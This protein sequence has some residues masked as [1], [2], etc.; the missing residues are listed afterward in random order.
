[1]TAPGSRPASRPAGALLALCAAV[2]ASASQA[3]V[4]VVPPRDGAA[5]RALAAAAAMDTVL[6]APGVH[7]GPLRI[8]GR[9]VVLRG[10]GATIAGRRT[11][12]VL[13]V[14][15]SGTVVEDLEV[16][17]G[18]S[19][20]I[21]TDAGIRVLS[22]SHVRIERVR[23]SDVLYGIYAERAE[24]LRVT[25]CDLTGRVRPLDE[26]GEGNGIHLWYC[27]GVRLAHNRVSRFLDGIYLS[28][29]DGTKVEAN[30]LRDNGRYGLHT[31]YCQ[32]NTLERNTFTRNV[33][34]VAIMFSNHLRVARNRIIQNRGPR[35]YGMLLRDC[36]D[37]AFEENWLVDN[38]VATFLDGSNR[39][40]FRG[41]LY[42][43]NGWGVLLFS[44]SADNDWAGNDFIHNDHPVALDM[45]FT[46]NRFDD[47]A[48]GNYWSDAATYDL[49]G[50]GVG[51]VPF[52][53]VTAFAFVSKQYPDL[54]LLAQSPAVA[55]L[56]VAERVFPALRPSEAVDRF[57][58]A[59]PVTGGGALAREAPA[60]ARPAWGHAALFAALGALGL[61][62]LRGRALA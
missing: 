37:G 28:F 19:R 47:G 51:D 17:G 29:A 49:D 23:L 43:D 14:A 56:G 46:R 27:R 52:A 44:S 62:G 10:P 36:S 7:R 25:G 16:R 42:Q 2:T 50:D 18:G 60:P 8:A 21:T 45:R 24:S 6:L 20:V 61:W 59:R 13:E 5:T 30:T 33:A 1:M 41:N 39:N 48:R 12:G 58:S 3:A 32:D 38:T 55:A 11:L 15:A 35:T 22:A 26:S 9:P 40:R 4:H 54:S 53:P 57:P 34:G 31:M